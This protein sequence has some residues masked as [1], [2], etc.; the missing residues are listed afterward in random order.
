MLN[1]RALAA[2]VVATGAGAVVFLSSGQSPATSP[3]PGGYGPVPVQPVGLPPL[4]TEAPTPRPVEAVQRPA[5]PSSTHPTPTN[6]TPTPTA[7]PVATQSPSA[8]AVK[9]AARRPAVQSAP[10]HQPAGT[11][12]NGTGG[13]QLPTSSKP[14][15]A[16]S[17]QAA[18]DAAPLTVL[19][20]VKGLPGL[21]GGL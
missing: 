11:E 9:P 15:C 6:P 16:A 3:P 7:R 21:I 2:A 1:R 19:D 13:W 12:P 17:T 10:V 5:A 20:I 18:P 14:S 8:T 4:V